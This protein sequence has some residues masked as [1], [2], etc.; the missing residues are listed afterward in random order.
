MNQAEY[1]S[2]YPLDISAASRSAAARDDSTEQHS[3]CDFLPSD[4]MEALIEED[5]ER[6][7]N[8][9]RKKTH[10]Q[11]YASGQDAMPSPAGSTF[12]HDSG[13][14]ASVLLGLGTGVGFK[15]TLPLKSRFYDWCCE[16]FTETQ[17]RQPEAEEPG[18]IQYNEQMWRQQRNEGIIQETLAQADIA[19]EC[20]VMLLTCRPLRSERSK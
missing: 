16:Y 19:R 3:P 6:L 18:S 20:F 10:Y 17:M 13:S 7:R 14:S 2:P 15:D 12:S 8:R 1:T 9:R 11:Q 4:V 5:M